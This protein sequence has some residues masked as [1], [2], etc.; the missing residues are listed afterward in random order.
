MAVSCGGRDSIRTKKEIDGRCGIRRSSGWPISHSLNYKLGSQVIYI[1]K[2]LILSSVR[3]FSR[4]F[5]R[6]FI[7]LFIHSSDLNGRYTISIVT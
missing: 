7:H 4:S 5:F 6:L 2:R 3:H 1:K